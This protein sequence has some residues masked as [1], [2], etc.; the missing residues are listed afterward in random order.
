MKRRTWVMS[1]VGAVVL[2]ASA[3][4]S[5]V[6]S[7]TAA[8]VPQATQQEQQEQQEGTERSERSRMP[9]RPADGRRFGGGGGGAFGGSGGAGDRIRGRG[10]EWRRGD[11]RADGRGGDNFLNFDEPSDEEWK[12]IEA[13][14]KK[15]SPKRL[16][17]LSDIGDEQRQQGLRNLFAAR[18]RAMEEMKERDPEIYELRLERMPVEDEVFALGWDLA[19]DRVDEP[20]AREELKKTLRRHLRKL[21]KSRLRERALRL[22]QMEQQLDQA[23]EKLKD[24][25]DEKRVDEAIEANLEDIVEERWPR[26]FRAPVRERGRAEEQPTDPAESFQDGS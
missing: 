5:V 9:F 8:T 24:D 22:K 21:V 18:Y 16:E 12:E 10:G 15:Y 13:F 25:L 26:H 6:L 17:R 20:E 7:Q 1:V 11:G 3:P 19:Q 4:T 2:A 23:Q 14:M